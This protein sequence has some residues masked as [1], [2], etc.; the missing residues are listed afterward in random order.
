MDFRGKVVLVTGAASGMG[1]ACA[2]A[3]SASGADVLIVDINAAGAQRV[4][5]EIGVG[6]PMIGDISQS[7][8][9]EACI[10]TV[11]SRHGRLDVVVNCAGI[12]LRADALGTSD[13]DWQRMLNVNVNGVFFM[14]RAAIPAM[15]KQ[16]GGAIINFGSIWGKSVREMWWP[17]ARPKAPFTSSPEPWPWTTSKKIFASTLFARVR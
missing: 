17:T 4:A 10:D 1:A 7:A 6:E 5:A 8:F 12:I 2:R 3:F 9:C 16:G 14:S 13:S 15:R 11:L